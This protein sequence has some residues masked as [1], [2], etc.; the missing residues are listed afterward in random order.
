VANNAGASVKVSEPL[1]LLRALTTGASR[2]LTTGN[3][4][5]HSFADCA[6][7]VNERLAVEFRKKGFSGS[8]NIGT[9]AGRAF[10]VT[11]AHDAGLSSVA[12]AVSTKHK[13]LNVL[14]SYHRPNVSSL[15]SGALTIAKSMAD[16]VLDDNSGSSQGSVPPPPPYPDSISHTLSCGSSFPVGSLEV[17]SSSSHDVSSSKRKAED[18]HPGKVVHV[19]N[20]YHSYNYH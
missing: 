14:N 5:K 9:H 19:H 16:L 7:R 18:E 20:I 8:G 1:H 13:D 17:S 6:L 2:R 10:Y 4:G 12:I 11:E 3:L 15:S